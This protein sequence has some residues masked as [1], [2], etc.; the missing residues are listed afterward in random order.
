[1]KDF[2]VSPSKTDGARNA[3]ATATLPKSSVQ[4]ATSLLHKVIERRNTIPILSYLRVE[5]G[6]QSVTL[7]GTDLDCELTIEV[8]AET[9][10]PAVFMLSHR[11]LHGLAANAAGPIAVSLQGEPGARTIHLSDGETEIT[12]NDHMPVEDYPVQQKRGVVPA[13]TLSQDEAA[14]LLRLTRHCISTEETRYYLNGVF[15]TNHPENW[16]VRAVATDG[17][18]LACIDTSVAADLSGLGRETQPGLIVHR[19]T[20][21]ILASLFGKGGNEPAQFAM[22]PTFLEL[23]CGPITLRSK[24]I[25]GT[26]PDYMRVIPS[27]SSNMVAHLSGA[28]VK[29]M[30]A[31]TDAISNDRFVVARLDLDA[32]KMS[33]ASSYP[34]EGAKASIP[35]QGN[36][37]EGCNHACLGFNIRYLNAQGAVTPNFTLSTASPGDPARIESEETNALWVIMPAR[38]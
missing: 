6:K 33:V 31:M 34:G 29:R 22:A 15:L 11:I 8:E 28:G 21:E 13:F 4:R 12:L 14:R 19:K 23:R 32:G 18:R 1:M 26:Y 27:P 7:D 37:A 38:L 36:R 17:H 9:E 30:T 3:I 25:D 16:T 2:A 24:T 5:I 20:V 35:L 10:G